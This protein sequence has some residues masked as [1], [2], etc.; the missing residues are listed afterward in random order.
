MKDSANE[1]LDH[2]AFLTR[3][4]DGSNMPAVTM[5]VL[6]ELDIP[7]GTLGFDHLETGIVAFSNDSAKTLADGIYETIISSYDIKLTKD[8]VE[9]AIRSSISSAWKIKDIDVWKYYFSQNVYD[10]MKKP[11]NVEFITRLGRF[12][13]LWKICCKEVAYNGR[14]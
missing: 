12:L 3:H 6:I 11:E 13:R 8:T 7:M 2:L 4:I 10:T 9:Q 14:K 5:L 1:V